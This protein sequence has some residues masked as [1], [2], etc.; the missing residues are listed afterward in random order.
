MGISMAR[1]L[2]TSL[3]SLLPLRI[4]LG[5]ALGSF[6]V[7]TASPAISAEPAAKSL[8]M[9]PENASLYVASL[10]NAE[11]VERFVDSNFWK[12]IRQWELIEQLQAQVMMQLKQ[13]GGGWQQYSEFTSHPENQQLIQVLKEMVSEEVFWYGNAEMVTT[14]NLGEKITN[15]LRYGPMLHQLQAAP[16]ELSEDQYV[17]KIIL[18]ELAANQED[19]AVPG[20]VFGFKV[21]NADAAKTQLQR[22]EAYLR[23]ML[24]NVP[25]LM[26]IR[27]SF[28]R[29]QIAGSDFLTLSLKG[30]LL[31]WHEI[32]FAELA[33]TP[34]QYD[35][36]RKKISELTVVISL[37]LRDGFVLLSVGPSTAALVK[38]GQGASLLDNEKLAP[39][40]AVGSQRFTNI[41]F[42]SQAFANSTSMNPQDVDEFVKLAHQFLPEVPGMDPKQKDQLR[43]DIEALAA[44]L[45]RYIPRPGAGLAFAYLNERGLETWSYDWT[46]NLFLD[47][48]KPLT[49]LKHLG[50][51]PLF[52]VVGRGQNHAETYNILAKWFRKWRTYFEQFALPNLSAQDRQ[53]YREFGALFFPLFSQINEINRTLLIPALADG[54]LGLVL[55]GNEKMKRWTTQLPPTVEPIALPTPA[56]LLGVS[57]ASLLEKSLAQ[58]RTTLNTALQRGHQM[59]PAQFPSLQIPPA[60]SSRALVDGTVGYYYPLPEQLGVQ[61]NVAPNIAIGPQLAVLSLLPKQ[62][63]DCVTTRPLAISTGPLADQERPLAAATY[64]NF[65]KTIEM[66]VPWANEAIRNYVATQARGPKDPATEESEGPRNR[67]PSGEDDSARARPLLKYVQEAARFLDVLQHFTSVTYIEEGAIVTHGEFAYEDLK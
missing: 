41:G 2:L 6:C 34:G 66:M 10:R 46:E 9:V 4:A 21:Q 20:F 17:Q 67:K 45:R 38:M 54:Q 55:A 3:L 14:I 58:Y 42:V 63:K 53:N 62:T 36:L 27:D 37:G 24:E 1:S 31:P 48:S 19:I 12:Q 29:V 57:E 39:L 59:D 65:S 60:K 25:E 40:K 23:V 26:P 50:S 43:K 30:E 56:L 61:K 5:L 16:N 64:I 33:E 18:D 51:D 44:D 47:G 15:T 52:A 13:P 7:T 49:L 11:Q 8:A 22:L 35:A 28:R 32:P